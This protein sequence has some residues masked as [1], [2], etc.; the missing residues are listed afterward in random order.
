MSMLVLAL[1]VVV[2]L[3]GCRAAQLAPTVSL[4]GT[5]WRAEEIEGRGVLAGAESTLAFDT[6]RR[7]S[8]Q[9]ACNR[10]VGT[11]EV[12]E[13][14]IRLKPAGATRMACPPPVMEQEARFLA[15][16]GAAT[17]FRRD[18]DRL[19]LLDQTQRVVLR[20][21]SRGLGNA[22]TSPLAAYAFECQDGREFVLVNVSGDAIDVI[23]SGRRLRLPQVPAAS[24]V[25]YAA[26]GVS[27]WTKGREATLVLDG[28]TSACVVDRRRSIIEDARARGAEFRASGNEPGWVW[29][30]LGDR[31]VFVGD[32]GAER[33]TT[34]R[35][36][37]QSGSM[38][39]ET[40][41]TAVTET[42]RLTVRILPRA[43]VDTMSG[44]RHTAT[45][46]VDLDGRTLRGCGDALR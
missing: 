27:V 13:S 30:L 33:V 43:C 14:T 26:D 29:E 17:T 41:Y 22:A 32:Y 36:P 37:Q 11:F 15:A 28:R 18:G 5:S 8:G 20:L 19:V 16:F 31:M 4:V 2:L 3:S 24:G 25:R 12:G 23:A 6:A 45:V 10:Y 40:R 39:G 38:P 46:E 7:I 44:A 21:A 35:P 34:P 42:H 9:A 1:T